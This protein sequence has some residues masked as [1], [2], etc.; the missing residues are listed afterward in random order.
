MIDPSQENELSESLP[1][2]H[3]LSWID[4]DSGLCT[5]DNCILNRAERAQQ[6]QFED[7]YGSSAPQ[8]ERE[9]AEVERMKR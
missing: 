4:D 8:N 5:H 6:C 2:G 1:C 3:A 7:Y 9:R